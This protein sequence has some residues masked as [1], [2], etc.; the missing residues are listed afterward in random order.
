MALICPPRHSE[1]RGK[2]NTGLSSSYLETNPWGRCPGDDNRGL[3]HFCVKRRN[4]ASRL[5]CEANRQ[6]L[7]STCCD[8]SK[9]FENL[10]YSSTN[11]Q[12]YEMHAEL[13]H[14]WKSSY[15]G[16][17]WQ[18]IFVCCWAWQTQYASGLII[19]R[20]FVP[21]E[22]KNTQL[23]AW[24]SMHPAPRIWGILVFG[25]I[26]KVFL[27]TQLF[28]LFTHHM[29]SSQQNTT[30][31]SVIQLSQQGPYHPSPTSCEISR[32]ELKVSRR[33]LWFHWYLSQAS[34]RSQSL[35]VCQNQPK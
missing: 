32:K 6:E 8:G 24:S 12:R 7:K 20:A 18:M 10:T 15:L 17:M 33:H 11:S 4:G 14:F 9:Q 31:L 28:F 30:P 23:D 5:I 29:P 34:H 3:S 19:A 21:E 1:A 35:C 22:N 16:R 2:T 27:K 25:T 13:D 26:S